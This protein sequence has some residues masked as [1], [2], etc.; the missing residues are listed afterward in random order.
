VNP[1]NGAEIDGTGEPGATV[2]VKDED[3][4]PVP[5]CESVVVDADGNWRCTPSTPLAPGGKITV[6]QT[7]P[8]GNESGPTVIEIAALAIKLSTY[9]LHPGETVT[10]YGY[11][12]HS[13]ETVAADM[14]S[15]PVHVGDVHADQAGH[16]EH[17]AWTVPADFEPGTHTAVLT[18]E[19]SGQVTATFEVL[20]VHVAAGGQLATERSLLPWILGL[21][22]LGAIAFAAVLVRRR[23]NAEPAAPAAG[24]TEGSPE[25]PSAV[26]DND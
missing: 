26:N 7:D 15:T 3:G 2:T 11:N 1:S 13:G 16:T 18:G 19:H 9:S 8:A 22:A 25:N 23:R 24:S 14:H 10:V 21:L 4:N 12:F 5:G 6:T 20:A 17:S